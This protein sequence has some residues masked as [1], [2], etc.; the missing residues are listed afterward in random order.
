M[1]LTG[2]LIIL[3]LWWAFVLFFDP[4]GFGDV[5]ATRSQ[6]QAGRSILTNNALNT[7]A[8]KPKERQ[9]SYART[10]ARGMAA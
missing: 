5:R 9:W 7:S 4:D 8:G 3:A 6:G 1:T 2:T 10:L